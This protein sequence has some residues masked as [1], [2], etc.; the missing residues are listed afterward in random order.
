MKRLFVSQSLVE[1]ESLKELLSTD[2]ILC[3]IRNQ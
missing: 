2:G 3:T 1:V